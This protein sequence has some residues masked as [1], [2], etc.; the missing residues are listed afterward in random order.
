MKFFINIFYWLYMLLYLLKI[1]Y[2]LAEYVLR[3]TV[4]NTCY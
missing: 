3:Y 2:F 4:Y 1:F